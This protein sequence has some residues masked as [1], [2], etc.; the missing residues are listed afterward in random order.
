M[1]RC[2]NSLKNGGGEPLKDCN[3]QYSS[4]W[5]P[6]IPLWSLKGKKE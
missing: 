2:S 1:L 3:N 6:L 4:G 5:Y